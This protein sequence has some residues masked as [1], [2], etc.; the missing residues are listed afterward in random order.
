MEAKPGIPQ[1]IQSL[2]DLELEA[3]LCLVADQH[4]C[5]IEADDDHLEDVDNELAQASCANAADK[6]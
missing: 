3:L 5:I 2:G 6:T 1:I 4:C